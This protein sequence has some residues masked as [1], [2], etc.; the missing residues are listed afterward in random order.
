M[1]G[2]P[3]VRPRM[4]RLRG[5][6]LLT[7]DFKKRFQG[8]RLRLGFRRAVQARAKEPGSELVRLLLRSRPVAVSE[9]P[10]PPSPVLAPLNLEQLPVFGS[11]KILTRLRPHSPAP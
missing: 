8:E 2:G 4:L 1:H 10:A 7:V 3:V 9:R 5:R 11:G 6:H